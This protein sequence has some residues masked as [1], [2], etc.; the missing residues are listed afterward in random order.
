MIYA[1]QPSAG[2]LIVLWS[3]GCL[4]EMIITGAIVGAIYGSGKAQ[5]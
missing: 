2:K 3:V 5:A 1:V 4:I